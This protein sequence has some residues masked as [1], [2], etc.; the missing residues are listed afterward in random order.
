MLDS[1]SEEEAAA[2][3]T[4]VARQRDPLRTPQDHKRPDGG[5]MGTSKDSQLAL[6]R[7]LRDSEPTMTED[8]WED[9]RRHFD[10]H[11]PHRPLFT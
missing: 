4:A 1:L 11:R 7:A 10:S 8:E 3:V 6:L 5:S 2:C 9:F